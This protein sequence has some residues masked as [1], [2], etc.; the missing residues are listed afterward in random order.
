MPRANRYLA[1]YQF[2][3]PS[4]HVNNREERLLANTEKEAS[5]IIMN[6]ELTC[7]YCFE[8]PPFRSQVTLTVAK[9]SARDE[10]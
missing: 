6:K 10:D 8:A 3:C 5:D 9:S 7:D 2:T 4:G 1:R